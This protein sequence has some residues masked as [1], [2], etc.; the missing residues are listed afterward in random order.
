LTNGADVR[1][2]A[3]FDGQD[4]PPQKLSLLFSTVDVVLLGWRL[5][6]LAD[7][8]RENTLIAVGILSKR[9]AELERAPVFVSAIK[10]EPVNKDV[11][12]Q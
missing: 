11:E 4:A 10:I 12:K 3:S 5:D 8:L 7:Q 2:C 9:Y 1:S 6:F